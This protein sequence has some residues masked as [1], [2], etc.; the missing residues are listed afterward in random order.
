MPVAVPDQ[1]IERDTLIESHATTLGVGPGGWPTLV[2]L[3]LGQIGRAGVQV[4]AL[5]VTLR[6]ISPGSPSRIANLH[7]AAGRWIAAARREVKTSAQSVKA[8]S[9][10]SPVVWRYFH[11]QC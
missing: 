11:S 8:A 9:D 1:G 7:T 3:H 5:G 6:E 4:G 2:A 10:P